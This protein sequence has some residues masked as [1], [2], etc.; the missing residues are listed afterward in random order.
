MSHDAATGYINRA[1]LSGG[2]IIAS[3]GKNQVGT[4]YEQLQNGAR[5]LDLR[6]KYLTNGTVI[7][8]H[9][10]VNIPVT[11]N[12]LL[13]DVIQWCNE[14]D[15]ELVLLLSS[16]LGYESYIDEYSDDLVAIE[17][18]QSIYSEMGVAYFHC[19]DVYGLTVEET[20]Q[21]A[22][23][24][25]GGYLL[26]LDGQDKYASFCGKSNWVSSELVT[27]YPPGEEKCTNGRN[28]VPMSHLQDYI[29]SSANNEASD[30]SSTLGPPADL[31][32]TPFN[33]IQALW[34]VTVNS[35]TAGLAHLSSILNDNIKSKVN[36]EMVNVIYDG[37]LD[38]ISLFAVDNVALNGNALLSVLRNACGQ[39]ELEKCGQ[40]IPPPKLKYFRMSWIGWTV[41]YAGITALAFS[42]VCR[43]EDKRLLNTF[44]ER[45]KNGDASDNSSRR[46]ELLKNGHQLPDITPF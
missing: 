36:E 10:M 43:K 22:E 6:P 44:F 30:D 31:Y 42:V 4:A 15:D 29:K 5:A 26:A 13:S 9:G 40:S 8:H 1:S 11:L 34:Q 19:N 18:I 25:S 37:K 12:Q 45:L 39:S 38:A 46:E 20:M 14:N 21:I 28:T 33:E 27:C 17:A 32:N 7:F 35:A 3:Y 24:S 16:E 23:L 2:G 41:L